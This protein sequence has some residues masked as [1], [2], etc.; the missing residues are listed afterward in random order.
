MHP[1]LV[2]HPRLFRNTVVGVEAVSELLAVLVRSVFGKELAVSGA[3]EGL[4]AGL[5]LDGLGG[6]VLCA[7]STCTYEELLRGHRA[8]HGVVRISAAT[9]PPWGRRRPCG[10][11]S[12]VLYVLLVWP[13]FSLHCGTAYLAP[14][15]ML[16]V[17]EG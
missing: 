8:R 13:C 15:P 1:S 16:L 11:A 4:E 9:W 10:R 3:L 2:R 6:G 17:G 14:L 12:A 5:A 7:I